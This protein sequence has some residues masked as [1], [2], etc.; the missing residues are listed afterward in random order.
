[1]PKGAR[2]FKEQGKGK[3]AHTGIRAG[4]KMGKWKNEWFCIDGVLDNLQ[5]KALK[6]VL[7]FLC[8]KLRRGKSDLSSL[9]SAKLTTEHI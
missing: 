6:N 3:T 9:I 5:T 4:D 7:H 8:V 2:K 1:M